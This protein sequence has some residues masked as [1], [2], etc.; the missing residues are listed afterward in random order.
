MAFTVFHFAHLGIVAE[1]VAA[2]HE[3]LQP[4]SSFLVFVQAAAGAEA[5]AFAVEVVQGHAHQLFIRFAVV[6]HHDLAYCL[7]FGNAGFVA[8][9][10]K[11]VEQ[12]A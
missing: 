1:V 11:Q 6:V 5:F 12:G 4:E 9:P 2:F 8:M 3:L 7:F 10:C